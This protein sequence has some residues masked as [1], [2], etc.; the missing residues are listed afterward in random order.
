MA[1]STFLN[2]LEEVIQDTSKDLT[3]QI[4]QEY[5]PLELNSS[6]DEE[7]LLKVLPIEAIKAL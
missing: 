6:E 7:I 2:P 5:D 3:E 4:A 1:I